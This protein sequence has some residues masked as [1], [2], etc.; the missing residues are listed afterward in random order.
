MKD[1]GNNQC[2]RFQKHIS[3]HKNERVGFFQVL[4][5]MERSPVP[6]RNFG[7]S[8]KKKEQVLPATVPIIGLG[9]SSFSTFFWTNDEETQNNGNHQFTADNLQKDHPIVQGWIA[10]IQHAVIACGINLLDTAPWYGHGTSEIVVGWALQELLSS[11]RAP[12]IKRENLCINTKVGRYEADPECQFDFSRKTTIDSAQ[13]SLQRLGGVQTIGYID[14][15]QLHD[16]EFAPT[17][18]V[19]I[20]ETIP[21]L[22]ECRSRGWCKALGL[23]GC[24]YGLSSLR[25]FLVLISWWNFLIFVCC[26]FL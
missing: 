9:C 3:V 2:G 8:L 10:T 7:R 24:T 26:H 6:Q 18:E 4:D 14:V 22:I 20:E 12:K 19:L 16:P 25:P 13:R 1:G 17:L 5:A 11:G 23:T 21:A 15:L